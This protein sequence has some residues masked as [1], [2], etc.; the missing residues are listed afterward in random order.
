MS[1][2]AAQ[3]NTTPIASARKRASER[4]KEASR[5]GKARPRHDPIEAV[6]ALFCSIRFAV[7][8]NIALAVA[9]MLGTIIPQMPTGLQNFSDQLAQFLNQAE[10][11]YGGFSGLLYWAGFYDLYNSL[12]FRLLVLTVVFS[13]VVCTLN[14]WQP[15]MR[16]ITQPLV[17]S[18][19]AFLAG[20]TEKAQ[21]R[22]VPTDF[23]GA[24]AAL[25]NALKKS[26]YRIIT[27]LSPGGEAL[28]IYADRD[29]W[30][31]LI[32]FVSHAALALLILTMAFMQ[33]I[34]WREQLVFYPGQQVN[35]GHNANFSVRMDNFAVQYYPNSTSAQEYRGT[36]SVIKSGTAVLTK[37]VLV[38]EPLRYEGISF[39]L[40]SYQPILYASASDSSGTRLPLHRIG[41]SGS[42][43]STS[44]NGEALVAFN[45]L[46]SN[47]LP[48]DVIQLPVTGHILTLDLTYYQDVARADN[49]NPPVYV[50]GYVDQNFNSPIYDAFLPRSGALKLPGYEAY[51]FTFR[52]DI[53]TTLDIT[54]DPG[55]WLPGLWF[56]IMSLGFTLS[57]YTTFTRCWAKITGS[58]DRPGAINIVLGGLA[59]KN[60]V[61]FEKDFERLA[62]RVKDNLEQAVAARLPDGSG[63]NSAAQQGGHS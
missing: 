32:T 47:N 6:W 57:L 44:S 31:K 29:R 8:L 42:I 20:L 18:G 34:G 38:N 58:A 17:Q 48:E 27:E 61:T 52:K 60:K 56:V 5:Q 50:K 41:A 14:R 7:V 15:V 11:R 40:S 16:L 23:D 39:Y 12:W 35:I 33:Y 55:L 1:Q 4:S 22:G 53:A 2:R 21:F 36:L 19:D 37:T 45:L 62:M 30:T 49:E 3:A 46:S 59:E 51:S 13:I 28:Y 43:T 24:E 9:A 54:W 63:R 10:A 25:R 26:R